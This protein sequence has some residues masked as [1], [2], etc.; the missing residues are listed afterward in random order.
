MNLT[1]WHVMVEPASD[2]IYQFNGVLSYGNH[3]IALS[4]EN[5]CLRGSVLRNT[6]YV[7]GFVTYSGM[8]TKIMM[9]SMIGPPKKSS[10]E[11]AY[12]YQI[13]VIFILMFVIAFIAA[14]YNLFW[15]ENSPNYLEIN[16]N[17]TAVKQWFQVFGTWILLFTN[18]IPISLLVTIEIVHFFQGVAMAWD[19][20]M[21][22]IEK[23]MAA[24]V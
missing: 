15:S 21:Y 2:K 3:D 12:G 17:D 10:L 22:S 19:A 8:Q 11:R 9:N 5:F 24:R 7:V 4:Y 20:D 13:R 23:D 16:V 18:M 6:K 14:F 1:G